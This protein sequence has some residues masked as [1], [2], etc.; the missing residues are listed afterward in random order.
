MIGRMSERMCYPR[1]DLCSS[2]LDEEEMVQHQLCDCPTLQGRR[3][4]CLG[5]Q[6]FRDLECLK[7]VPLLNLLRF[8][9]CKLVSLICFCSIFECLL[10][11][12]VN[13]SSAFLFVEEG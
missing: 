10:F 11:V 1:N 6:S 5:K 3:L 9:R 4:Q 12:R 13:F 8:I 7:D 2:C